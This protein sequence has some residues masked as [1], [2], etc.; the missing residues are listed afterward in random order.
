[1]G[2][3]GAIL[4]FLGLAL[5]GLMHGDAET[6]RG[7]YLAMEPAAWVVLVPLAAA[8]LITGLIEA[9]LTRWGLFRHYWVVFKLLITVFATTVLL[10]YMRTF[11]AMAGVAADEH[12]SLEAVRNPS[13]A[14]HA[15]AALMLLVAATVLAV[16]KPRGLT[17][18][19]RRK[20]AP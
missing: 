2:W 13:P 1:V 14:L 4:A 10:I 9:L 12:A 3:L 6:V 19:G 20:A 17:P 8:S 15:A 18:Y 16:F 5:V 11:D 7:I